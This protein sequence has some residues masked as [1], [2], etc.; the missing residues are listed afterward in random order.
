LAIM[1]AAAEAIVLNGEFAKIGSKL[2]VSD[3]GCG[4]ACAAAALE[5]AALNVFINTKAMADRAYAAA[6][7]AKARALM[8]QYGRLA[9][10]IY[11]SVAGELA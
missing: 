2:A 10:D 6:V 3:A 11:A 9:N 8:A 1:A 4:A 5:A 7:P